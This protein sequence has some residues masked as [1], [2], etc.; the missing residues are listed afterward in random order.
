MPNRQNVLTNA[1]FIHSYSSQHFPMPFDNF[2][3]QGKI[4]KTHLFLFN[5]SS[6][7]RFYIMPAIIYDCMVNTSNADD[8]LVVHKDI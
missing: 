5:I 8:I 2:I 1:G 3:F 4:F 6:V 7:F